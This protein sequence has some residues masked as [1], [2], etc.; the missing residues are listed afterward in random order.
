MDLFKD[1]ELYCDY[2]NK[3][4]DHYA[5]MILAWKSLT[6]IHPFGGTADPDIPITERMKNRISVINRPEIRLPR[7]AKSWKGF[8]PYLLHEFQAVFEQGIRNLSEN[9]EDMLLHL[10]FCEKDKEYYYS[11]FSSC[12][13]CSN[14]A[15]IK[16]EPIFHGT[17]AGFRLYAV[18]NNKKIK[19]IFHKDTY[20]DNEETIHMGSMTVPYQSGTRYY[21]TENGAFIHDMNDS[22]EIHGKQI[23]RIQKK[24][25]SET[26]VCGNKIYYI[27]AK[28]TLTQLEITESGNGIKNLSSVS[29]FSYFTVDDVNYCILNYYFGKIIIT[30]NGTNIEIDYHSGIINY[31]I[32]RDKVTGKWM[33]LL[34]DNTGT[35]HTFIINCSTVEYQTDSFKYSC[36]LNCPCISNSTIFLPMD[37]KIRGYAYHKAVF[38]DFECS[39]VSEESRLIKEKNRFT[40]INCENVY[41]MEP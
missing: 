40:I 23:C 27:S 33:I 10:S 35:F 36:P 41:V 17:A 32:H 4:T 14:E 37:G 18:Y 25:K 5:F 7:M 31:G 38:K 30:V 1:P 3:D 24:H 26:Q 29:S 39:A 11:K 15:Q 20:L 9:M 8:S 12:P 2:F 19:T 21:R 6:R 13:Y 28:N 34:E 16:E 22:F